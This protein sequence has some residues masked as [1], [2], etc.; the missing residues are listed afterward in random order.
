MNPTSVLSP[1][2]V[3]LGLAIGLLHHSGSSIEFDSDWFSDPGPR[4]SGALADDER[5]AALVRFVDAVNG[6]GGARNEGGITFLKLFDAAELGGSGAPHLVVQIVVDDRSPT[7][8]EVGVGIEH[9]TATPIVTRTNLTVPLYRTGKRNG[10]STFP[11]PQHFAL[12]AGAPIRLSSNITTAGP[13]DSSGFSLGGVSINVNA[14]VDGSAAPSIEIALQQLR[15][16]GST[17]PIDI[18]IGGPGST[19]EDALLSLVL[20]AV[21]AG[22]STLGGVGGTAALAMLDLIGLGPGSTLPKL[23]LGNL[24]AEGVAAL[25]TWISSVM[26]DATTRLAWLDTLRGVIGGT[27]SGE[28][29]VIPIPGSP[30]EL[31]LSVTTAPGPGG[32]LRVTPRVGLALSSVLG[33]GPSAVR[34][35]AEGTVDVLTIDLVDGSLQSVPRAEVFVSASGNGTSRLIAVGP[36]QIG[37]ARLGVSVVNGTV[38]PLVALVD[39]AAGGGVHPL[40]DLSSADAV[41]ASA[42]QIA[43][44]LAGLA[45]DS[46]GATGVHLKAL[47]G[48]TPPGGVPALDAAQLFTDPLRALGAWWNTLLHAAGTPV[49]GVLAHLR[50]LVVTDANLALPVSGDGTVA[51]PWSIN[52]AQ[53]VSID[54]WR[55]GSTLVVAPTLGFRVDS[56]GGGCTVITTS[57]RAELA[58]IDLVGGHVSLMRRAELR[59]ALRGRGLDH[60]RLALGPVAI[61]ADE[62]GVAAGWS[63]ATGFAVSFATPG[64]GA[65][66]GESAAPGLAGGVVPLTIPTGADWQSAVFADVENLIGVLAAANPVGWLHDIVDLL[67]WTFGSA[68]G[69]RL[70]LTAVVADATIELRRWALAVASDADIISRLTTSVARV[71]TG[72]RRGL[73]G[74]IGGSGSPSDPWVIP[75][76]SQPHAPLLTIAFGPSGP[77]VAPSQTSDV[78]RTWFPGIDG[79]PA[80]GLA[81]ALYDEAASGDDAAALVRGR[82]A[83][84]GGLAM[85][86]TRSV[87]T[88]G[89]VAAPPAPIAGLTA[90]SEPSMDWTDWPRLSV[91]TALGGPPVPTAAIVRVAIG[92]ASAHP[93]LAMPVERIVDLSAPALAPESFTVANPAAGEWF[94]VLA[95]RS[96]AA[97]SVADPTG[98]LGQAARLRRVVAALGVGR[99]VV[100]VA[101]GGAGHAA[102]LA[103]DGEPGVTHLV[104]LGTPWSAVAFE[105][106]RTGASADALRLLRA[107]LPPV[108]LAEPDDDD[109]ALGRAI[110]T[111]LLDAGAQADLEAPR[112]STPIRAGLNARAWFGAIDRPAVERAATAVVAAG[113]AARARARVAA[114]SAVPTSAELGLRLTIPRVTPPTGHGLTVEGSV[115]IGLSGSAFS[116]GHITAAPSATVQL[117]IAHTDDW[118]IGGPGTTPSGGAPS[119]EVRFVEVSASFGVGDRPSHVELVLHEVSALGAYRD[120][121]VV[122]PNTAAT[123]TTDDLPFLPEARA[124]LAAVVTRLRTAA[125]GT[126]AAHLSALLDGI[127]LSVPAGLVPDALSHLLHAPAEF[128]APVLASAGGRGA[129]LDACAALI[130][131]AS[132]A[133]SV[134]TVTRSGDLSATVSLD[135]AARTVSVTAAGAGVLAWNVGLT[136]L[137]AAHP[138]GSFTIGSP[139]FN[140]T[141][142]R[143]GL[144]PFSLALVGLS[145]TGSPTSVGV[146]PTTDL[147]GLADFAVAALPAEAVRLVLDAVRTMDATV[148]SLLDGL[149]GALGL[150]GP[151]DV[152]GHRDV[153]PPLALFREPVPWFRSLLDGTPAQQVDRTVDLFEGLKPFVGLGGTPRGHWPITN[154][155]ALDVTA[156]SSGP[157]IAVAI[158]PTSWLGGAGRA[159]FAAGI[160]LGLTVASAG[161]PTPAV[162][163]FVGLPEAVP[164][165]QHRRAVHVVLDAGGL[166]VLLRP[167]AGGDLALYPNPAGLG[168]LLSAGVDALLPTALTAVAALTGSAGRDQVGQLV[169]AVGRGLDIVVAPGNAAIR[170]TFDGAKLHALADD[171]ALHLVTRAAAL[172]AEAVAALHPLIQQLPGNPTAVMSAGNLVVTVRGI[173]LTVTPSPISVSIQGAVSGLPFVGG[174]NGGFTADAAG[175]HA[176]NFGVGPATF[177]LGGPKVRPLISGGRVGSGGWEIAL[178]LGLDDLAVTANGHRELFARWREAGGLAMVARTRTGSANVDVT[179]AA[180]VA[181]FAADATLELLGSWLIGLTDV[182]TL[183][184][185][186]VGPSNRPVRQILQGSLLSNTNDHAVKAGVI[187]SLPGSLFVLARKLVANLPAIPIGPFELAL[188]EASGVVGL[189]LNIIDAAKGLELNPG[190][191]IVLALVTDAAWIEPPSGVAPDPGIIVD[192]MSISNDPVPVVSV[193]PGIEINGVGL[194]ISKASG[195][196]LDAGLRIEAAAV[197]LFGSLTPAS[198]GGV[199]VSGGIEVEIEGLAVPMSGGGGNNA[200]AQGVVNDAGGSGAPPTPKF[201]P[202]LAIQHHA[203]TNGVAVS[204]SAGSGDGPW[205]L[206]IQ[207]AFG[208]VYIEQ[209]GLGTTHTG[210]PPTSPKRLETVSLSIDG[211]VS[212]FGIMAS[213]DKLRLTYHVNRPFFAASSWEVDLDGFAI[214]SSIGGLTLAGALRRAPLSPPLVGIEYLG[215]LKIGFGGYGVDLFGGYAHPTGPQGS[216]ASF[217][218]FGALHAPLGGPP[219]FFVTGVGL[220]FGIN[221]ELTAPTMDNITTNPFMVAMKALG[222]AP[223][224]MTQ[225]EQMRQQIK[226]AQ[227]QYWVAAG[228]SF[229]SFV[230]ISGEVVVTVAFGDGL[231]IAVLGLARAELPSPGATL[232]SI[233]LAL[234]A[235]FSTKEGTVLIAAQLTENSWLLSTSVRLTGGFA[236]QSWWKGPNAGQFV[237]TL[238][239]YHP[240]FHH[241]GYPTVP[242]LGLRWSVGDNISIIGESYFALCSEALMAGTSLEVAAHFGPAHASLSFGA[243]GIVFFDPFWFS[244][245]AWAE[246]RAGIRIWLLFGTVDIEISLG[247]FVEITGPPIHVVGHFEICGFDVPFEFGDA[248]NPA[249]KALK[250]GEFRDKYLRASSDA[251][252]IQASLAKGAV[253]A[254]QRADGSQQKVPDGSALNPFLVIPEFELVLRTTAPAVDMALTHGTATKSLHVGAP[255]LG[256]APMYSHTLTSRLTADLAKLD[257]PTGFSLAKVK[258]TPR[259]VAAFPKGVWGEAPNPNAPQVPAGEVIKASDGFVFSTRL[260]DPAG[261]PAID[262]HQVE[263]P[264]AGR[265]PL[266]FVTNTVK[267]NARLAEATQLKNIADGVRVGLTTADG[268]FE[269]AAR[270]LEAGGYGPVG[271]AAL[272]GERAA[273]PAFGSLA[274]DLVRAP[275]AVSSKAPGV[276]VDRSEPVKPFVAPMVKAIVSSPLNVAL[277]PRARTTVADAGKAVRVTAPTLDSMQRVIARVAPSK[278]LMRGRRAISVS[279]AAPIPGTPAPAA[280]SLLAAGNVPTTR[281]ATAPLA[282]VANARPTLA[283]AARLEQMTSSLSNGATLHEGELAVITVVSRSV[284]G[285]GE[286]IIVDGGLSRI[287]ALAAGGNVLFDDVFEG[288]R[289]PAG[290]TELPPKTER[291]IVMALGGQSAVGGRLDGWYVGQS[292]PLVG[293]DHAIGAGVVVT[294]A[295]NK[296]GPHADRGDGGWANT[297]DL[298]AAASVTTRFDAPVRSVA[299]AIDDASGA[300]APDPASVLDMLLVGATRLT[301]ASGAPIPPIVVVQGVRTLL[302]YDIVPSFGRPSDPRVRPA[303]PNIKV[304]IDGTR[305]GQLAGVVGSLD[306][307]AA[308]VDTLTRSGLD[309]A[310][311]AALPGGSGV[312]RIRWI[313]AAAKDTRTVA[314][315]A[316]ATT[317][318]RPRRSR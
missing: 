183:L 238:G 166:R 264:L 204:L 184:D 189:R 36:I 64:L 293:W 248:G 134:V 21:K 119:L 254:G 8:V 249:D 195:P 147:D 206:P 12:A 241:D 225:L 62:I 218:A 289:A 27:R 201:S 102:R 112:P 228:I 196:L 10:S 29:L 106:A 89:L 125:A 280:T 160:S 86:L 237:V 286:S 197:H 243:D 144:V 222:P 4:L 295:N 279:T 211:N 307:A 99:P 252:V 291:V 309:A 224:P 179:T 84:A 235:R 48:I 41:V 178:G 66:L 240:R 109:L 139:G 115:T 26:N 314:R 157:T 281:I 93:W 168:A 159:P 32:H 91:E 236:F 275:K 43:G 213:V 72:N 108:D 70:S 294:F 20:G 193:H 13:L 105:T 92:R 67:G 187:T 111:G 16:P 149:T 124:V 210:S 101:V 52:V 300:S 95:T 100:I 132:R 85:L 277:A 130:P 262:Y 121:V 191:D 22:A 96:D 74:E 88:D 15:M 245:S 94:V 151:P 272:R 223:D 148:G 270:L 76:G 276:I 173:A 82:P 154:G 297:R 253:T 232:V 310:V 79:L 120:R 141:A 87:A 167:T 54:I 267:A 177:D 231:D 30:V 47:L 287:I 207:R 219:A 34:L 318:A 181:L 68:S 156:G 23:D 308:L 169:G 194:R 296:A 145:S 98:V 38:V 104:T 146:W 312:R 152:N 110:V 11:V 153:I 214:A 317:T 18:E 233:E 227:G 217:F 39:V 129:L 174:V 234:I 186:Q 53:R 107:L 127:G 185:V 3:D 203:G 175:L 28:N 90:A 14:P 60:A 305:H 188:H 69:N 290:A 51:R 17:T 255:E 246:V 81:Q 158:D 142:L 172:L 303:D 230:L 19:I 83:L 33:A 247:V 263:L 135:L 202:G 137:G 45:L 164:T 55:E 118:L 209:I 269:V 180:D 283:G 229:T 176:W 215:M 44:E 122:R 77:V 138:T 7:Y 298:V 251:Q 244:V 78:L 316:G 271:V 299:V 57:L 103:A 268:R 220:G 140:T 250:A 37:A 266:P 42:G 155:I 260:D 63:A 258:V 200:V 221:R 2:I 1:E 59:A 301:D 192:I 288:R 114:A 71:F 116:T 128:A 80:Q 117:T 9:S 163:L 205:Y 5:R 256:V 198:G 278:L 306:S 35:S 143:V 40:V 171:P 311:G 265:K 73:V 24:A 162:E 282:T 212:L 50:D 126:A 123:G 182:G 161:Q 136:G 61:V 273:V 261:A 242:R 31:R 97:L 56:L 190:S 133:G 285:S 315:R 25:R 302:V 170:A 226:P 313:S 199:A 113:L 75:L 259:P 131:G 284:A 58:A 257:A 292:L 274:D 49:P 6:E 216:F 239:G 65:V 304:I 150:L 165:A 46:F 208:P